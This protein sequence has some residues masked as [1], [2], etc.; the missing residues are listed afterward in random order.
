MKLVTL[1]LNK[2]K[3]DEQ[4][5]KA[6]EILAENDDVELTLYL[7]NGRYNLHF[8]GRESETNHSPGRGSWLQA[9]TN[10]K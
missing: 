8:M 10:C 5:I 2:N 4:I 1:K 7:G 6:K 9:D 3:I